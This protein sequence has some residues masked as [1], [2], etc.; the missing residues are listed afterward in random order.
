MKEESVTIE[1]DNKAV[2]TGLWADVYARD[3]DAVGARFWPDGTYTDVPSPDDDIAVGPVEVAARLRLGLGPLEKIE[4][5]RQMM[6]ADGNVVVT[7]HVEH[8][9]WPSGETMA[10]PFCSVHELRDGLVTRWADYWDMAVLVAAA[11]DWWF[12]HVMGGYR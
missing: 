1:D 5:G 2:I 12:E 7:E 11:P 6:M 8:W 3:F 4:H 9:T 10:L